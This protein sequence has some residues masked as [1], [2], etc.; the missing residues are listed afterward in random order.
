MFFKNISNHFKINLM[1]AKIMILAIAMAAMCTASFAQG[2]G[3]GRPGGQPM[4]AEQQAEWMKRRVDQMDEVVKLTADEKK[5]VEA[6]FTENMKK[7][8]EIFA[9]G[10]QASMRE[11][12]TAARDDQ[13]KKLEAL[14]GAERYKKYTESLPRMGQGGQRQGGQGG[15]GGQR[16][17]GQGG[18][19]PR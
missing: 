3:G 15:Q 10:D 2:P 11:K 16:P 18:Q 8:Q 17:G 19:R 13:N 4:T 9:S 1:K 6:I 7:M 12:M 14:L 5:K